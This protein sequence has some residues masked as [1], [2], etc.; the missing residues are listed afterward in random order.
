MP[1]TRLL[2]K[3][4]M[5]PTSLL[6][7]AVVGWLLVL[8]GRR[9]WGLRLLAVGL[10]ALLVLGMPATQA[11][12][13]RPLD[14]YPPLD[15]ATAWRQQKG[16]TGEA[17]V[18]LDGGARDGAREYGAQTVNLATL[19]R[20]RYGAWV[21]RHL[22]RPILVS[23][24]YGQEMAEALDHSF[25]VPTQW[26]EGRSRNTHESARRTAL[27]L[28]GHGI[29]RIYLVTHCWHMRRAVAAFRAAGLEVKAAP[30]GFSAPRRGPGALLPDAGALG[31]SRYLLHEWG[32]LLWYRLRYGYGP[33]R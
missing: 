16:A 29:G 7:L 8:V 13:L 31:E 27:L 11:L 14:R 20:L 9:R 15:L 2:E 28:Q 4:F 17:I 23:G 21:Y 10:L 30:M 5:P 26:V 24:P 18:I 33:E 32:G 19:E 12:L 1:W 25:G 22:A 3:L 6:W